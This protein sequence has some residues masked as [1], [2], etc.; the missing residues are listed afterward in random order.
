MT[1]NNRRFRRLLF[2]ILC[3]LD[4]VFQ[5]RHAMLA[6][7]MCATIKFSIANFHAM[8]DDHAPTVSTLWCHCM[9]RTLKAIKGTTLASF[10][11]LKGLVI[12]VSTDITFSHCL[13][14]LKKNP[15]LRG[16]KT[17]RNVFNDA[18][19]LLL[20]S[21]SLLIIQGRKNKTGAYHAALSSVL[22]R[23]WKCRPRPRPPA[24]PQ[25]AFAQGKV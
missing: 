10:D 15:T 7:A 25:A 6:R 19:N 14:F 4:T 8:P 12:L 16:L 23:V 11:D 24:G 21:H 3:L 2:F 22:Y 5:L 1:D 17:P 18:R 13:S 9:D 20:P